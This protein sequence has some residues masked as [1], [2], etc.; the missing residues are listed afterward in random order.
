M[1]VSADGR[2]VA[3]PAQA[4]AGAEPTAQA[5]PGGW[6][7]RLDRLDRALFPAAAPPVSR[8]SALLTALATLAAVPLSLVRTGGHGPFDSLWAE[9]GSGFV[10]DSL[11]LGTFDALKKG[12][13][14]YFVLLPRLIA[15]PVALVP[16]QRAPVVISLGAAACTALFAL[17]AYL[18]SAA[19]LRSV[20]ARLLVS[21]PV[22]ATPVA[23]AV[24]ANNVATLQ[25]AA[26]YAAFWALMWMPRG[27]AAR[28]LAL[29]VVVL[30]GLSTILIVA[31]VPVAVVR[32]VVR[33]DRWSYAI[34]GAVCLTVAVQAL[35][36]A[37]G[38]T[39]R[40]GLSA[41]R[42]DPLWALLEWV[43]WAMPYSVFGTTVLGSRSAP[44][45]LVLGLLAYA[46]LA[47]VVV[48]ALRRGSTGPAWGLAALAAASSAA[49][50]AA[51]V[52]GMGYPGTEESY[53]T[54][55]KA[56]MSTERYLLAP[57]LL[58]IA[59]VVALL[60]PAPSRPSR[61]SW[62]LIGY[63]LLVV[64]VCATQLRPDAPRNHTLSW[65]AVVADAKARCTATGAASVEVPF[66][67][68]VW[69]PRPLVPCRKL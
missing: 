14:G 26:L 13:N 3:V 57:V 40:E 12:L 64:V 4:P 34:S 5:A 65:S 43:L 39:S 33:R 16:V 44:L 23:G 49:I 29:A 59:A 67:G 36:L 63:G 56:L 19:Y 68:P 55:E 27:W 28:A 32:A 45:R 47:A 38:A 35:A 2:A 41:P 20:P 42:L 58:L 9:D 25:F 50:L 15:E 31:L 62:P 7:A 66:G 22:V 18:A 52:M 46:V 24:V 53:L 51:E 11:N 30:T 10:H 17:T 48:L 69:Y 37:T 6:R 60:R 21:L 54:P 1:N 61:P 8:R